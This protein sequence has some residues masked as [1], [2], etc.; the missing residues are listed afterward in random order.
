MFHLFFLKTEAGHVLEM[1][2]R[3]WLISASPSYKLGSYIK[4]R[5]SRILCTSAVLVSGPAS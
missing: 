3:F 1:F 4:K 5:V 2:L